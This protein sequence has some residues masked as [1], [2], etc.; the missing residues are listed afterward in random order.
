[1][2]ADGAAL[3][4]PNG[5]AR[6]APVDALTR[7]R[8]KLKV[9]FALVPLDPERDVKLLR[10]I[11]QTSLDAE[12]API[13]PPAEATAVAAEPARPETDAGGRLDF[14]AKVSHEVRT[15]LNSII[16]FAELMLQERFGPIGNKRYTRLCRGHPSERTL[17]ALL[18]QRPARHLQ[19]RCRQVR[20]Q[21]HRGRRAGD[22][23]GLRGEPAA[24]GQA[25]AH[26]A[27]DVARARAADRGRRSAAAQADPAQPAH[28]RHQVHQGRRPGDRVG[29]AWSTASSA[30]A[31]ATT[32]SA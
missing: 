31:C 6:S 2:L 27:Q 3:A 20:A 24:A 12:T 4:Q 18:A 32:A 1:M 28:Q 14:L 23:R 25:R 10:L 5:A 15:P 9:A 21:F 16:G 19:D 13:P 26:R 29:H 17:R 8:R 7:S 11:D 22:R 30:C